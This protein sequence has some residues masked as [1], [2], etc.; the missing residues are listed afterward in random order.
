MILVWRL[1]S[2]GW[3]EVEERG[4]V[5]IDGVEVTVSRGSILLG[6]LWIDGMIIGGCFAKGLDEIIVLGNVAGIHVGDTVRIGG[7][8]TLS[9]SSH[10][11]D[12]GVLRSVENSTDM[13]RPVWLC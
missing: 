12:G 3:L 6:L 7:R 13:E 10:G 4:L 5:G 8:V 1:G 11:D 2:G 9:D